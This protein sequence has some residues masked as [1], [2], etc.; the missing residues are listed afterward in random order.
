[1]KPKHAPVTYPRRSRPRT[2]RNRRFAR[3]PFRISQ[4]PALQRVSAGSAGHAL[5]PARAH[6]ERGV[7]PPAARERRRSAPSSPSFPSSRRPTPACRWPTASAKRCAPAR[8][9]GRSAKR[10]ASR[11]ASA[12]FWSSTPANRWCWWTISCAPGSKLR[13]MKELLESRGARVVALAVIIYQPTPHT[14]RFRRV[15]ALLSG[16]AERQL[17][18]RCRALRSLQGGCAGAEESG[19][20]PGIARVTRRD[21]GTSQV[22]RCGG[23]LTLAI[24]S[25][26]GVLPASA[27]S[28]AGPT[29]VCSVYWNTSLL[30]LGHVARIEHVYDQ[31]PGERCG[32]KNT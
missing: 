4:R 9:I 25:L 22:T 27:C 14:A 24:L 11:C 1:M 19:C 18:C 30:F 28:C 29:P 21:R 6:A 3:R 31:P 5:L 10:P 13:E 32:R 12:S 20:R 8:F 15:A 17:L 7:E 23:P 2:A 16:Q 26:A